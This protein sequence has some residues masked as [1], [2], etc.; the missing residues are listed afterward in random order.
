[1]TANASPGTRQSR[2]P[3]SAAPTPSPSRRDGGKSKLDA[4]ETM[5]W[6][7]AAITCKT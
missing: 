2:K 3:L 1:M 5:A 6:I 4:A 7:V